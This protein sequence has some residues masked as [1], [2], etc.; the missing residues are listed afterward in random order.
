[1]DIRLQPQ[2][3]RDQSQNDCLVFFTNQVF[4]WG[5][6]VVKFFILYVE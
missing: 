4:D 1:M 5:D 6:S 2:S 3:D